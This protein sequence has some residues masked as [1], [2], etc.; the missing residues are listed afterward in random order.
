MITINRNEVYTIDDVCTMF[1]VQ[2]STVKRWIN[3]EGL[4]ARALKFNYF[5][6][7]KNLMEW[8]E[9]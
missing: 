1:S 2:E 4:K 8:L 3:K 7:G 5:I 6:A 9:L